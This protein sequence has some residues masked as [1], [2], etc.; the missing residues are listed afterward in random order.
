MKIR[1]EF[2]P[3]LCA[4]KD[5]TR[6][7]LAAP[8]LDTE[9]SALVAT[10]GHRVTICPVTLEDGDTAGPV[11]G[12]ALVEARKGAPKGC[13]AVVRANGQITVDTKVGPVTMPRPEP[14]QFPAWRQVIPEPRKAVIAFNPA[15]LK[16]IA[17]AIGADAVHGV[18]LEFDPADPHAPIV[19]RANRPQIGGDA[20]AALMPIRIAKE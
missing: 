15:Y 16:E 11:P 14:V 17:D 1:R 7:H 9:A 13:D 2:K 3:E 20:Y 18:T 19:V 6:F 8:Y 4:S 10:D 5:P 12:R